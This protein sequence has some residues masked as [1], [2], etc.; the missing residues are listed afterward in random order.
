LGIVFR[1]LKSEVN[2]MLQNTAKN[3]TK[4]I[5][6][7]SHEKI[8]HTGWGTED[9]SQDSEVGWPCH[10]TYRLK[11]AIGIAIDFDADSTFATRPVA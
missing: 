7:E 11:I 8:S 2:L 9:R 3:G 10:P 1:N 6:T 4:T 5:V